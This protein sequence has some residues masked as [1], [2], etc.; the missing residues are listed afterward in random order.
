MKYEEEAAQL[1]ASL[2]RL[3]PERSGLV[4]A[5]PVPREEQLDPELH[6]RVHKEGLGELKHQGIRG[7]SVTPVLLERFERETKEE[8]LRVNKQIV[9]NN[10][11]LA[12]RIAVACA[13]LE[14]REGNRSTKR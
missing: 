2:R 11:R 10:A 4:V 7:K 1:I 5:N 6:D 14:A 3:G 9:R 12:A 13:T 8:S